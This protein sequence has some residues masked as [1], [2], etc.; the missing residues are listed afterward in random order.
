MEFFQEY[1]IVII[2]IIFLICIVGTAFFAYRE[3]KWVK[4][5]YKKEDIIALGFG[6][7]C[8]G[9]ASDQGK[10]KKD[11][12]FLLIHRNGLLFK[13]RFSNIIF[14]IPGKSIQKAYHATTHKGTRLYHSAVKVDF[15]TSPKNHDTIAFKMAYPPQ[16]IKIITKAFIKISS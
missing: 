15:S 4:N 6:I 16:W 14:D 3:K 8:Y 1:H 12:G 11:K 10:P 7:T 9:L 13:S 2:A 5:N